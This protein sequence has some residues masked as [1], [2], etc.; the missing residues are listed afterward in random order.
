MIKDFHVGVKGVIK[1]G[2]ECLVLQKGTGSDAY[3][4][5]PG[6]RIDNDETLENTLSR[7]LNEEL[8]SLKKYKVCGVVGT[9]RLSKNNIDDKGLML[10]FFS[11]EAEDFT[12]ELSSEHVDFKWVNKE[13]V[14]ELLKSDIL[15]EKG[16]YDAIV[17]ALD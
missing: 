17:K 14:S 12:V 1:V 4:D 13:N 16:Y 15:I 2:N 6:G 11:V 5:V 3:W 7:E 8:P 10:I 9:Y